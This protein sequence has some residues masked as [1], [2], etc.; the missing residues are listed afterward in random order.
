MRFDA[1]EDSIK[2][3]SAETYIKKIN[4]ETYGGYKDWRLPT[5]D[6]AMSLMEREEKRGRYI[7]EQFDARLRSIWTSD[8]LAAS[9]AWFV[10]FDDGDCSHRPFDYSYFVR[11]VR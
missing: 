5:L 3:I 7:A 10:N 8:K 11:A 6:E 9:I 4:A 2:K 1:A